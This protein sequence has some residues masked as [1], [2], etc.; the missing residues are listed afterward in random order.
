MLNLINKI[1]FRSTYEQ[2][3]L[4][5]KVIISMRSIFHNMNDLYEGSRAKKLIII[6]GLHRA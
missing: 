4:I 6:E 2:K 5:V 1:L 3:E